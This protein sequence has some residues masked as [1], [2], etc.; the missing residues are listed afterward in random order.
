VNNRL[1]KLACWLMLLFVAVGLFGQGASVVTGIASGVFTGQMLG[2]NGSVAAPTYSF[3]SAPT[4][5]FYTNGSGTVFFIANGVSQGFFNSA[6]YLSAANGITATHF[7]QIS[8]HDAAGTC[9][10]SSGTSCSVTFATAYGSTPV[11][12][13]NSS[14]TASGVIAITSISTSGATFTVPTSGSYTVYYQCFGNPS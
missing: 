9:S 13:A 1:F 6:G 2:P 4:T 7:G 5:G 14:A 8:N 10:I 11:C 12:V 3:S